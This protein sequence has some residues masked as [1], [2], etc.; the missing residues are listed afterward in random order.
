MNVN[1]SGWIYMTTK[2]SKR[3]ECVFAIGVGGIPTRLHAMQFRSNSSPSQRFD[4]ETRY[5]V[6]WKYLSVE[7]VF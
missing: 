1:K 4:S 5:R 3:A 6:N 2:V 7:N